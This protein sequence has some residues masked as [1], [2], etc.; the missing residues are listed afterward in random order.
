MAEILSV[1]THLRKRHIEKAIGVLDDLD[2]DAI[3]Q[4]LE[5]FYLPLLLPDQQMPDWRTLILLDRQLLEAKATGVADADRGRRTSVRT[6]QQNDTVVKRRTILVRRTLWQIANDVVSCYEREVLQILGLRGSRPK[7]PDLT[8]DLAIMVR[9]RLRSDWFTFPDAP[10]EDCKPL[11]REALAKKL[12]RPI[13]LLAETLGR[14]IT[15]REGAVSALDVKWDEQES[16][17]MQGRAVIQRLRSLFLQIGEERLAAR[18]LL[19]L[20]RTRSEAADGD[21]TGNDTSDDGSGTPDGGN[22]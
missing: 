17:L 10:R 12:D 15:T 5:R 22:A 8:L 2:L 11:D 6:S 7:N 4:A 9:D 3:V 1:T 16:A 14:R 20:P 21:D 18:L 13:A 19:R